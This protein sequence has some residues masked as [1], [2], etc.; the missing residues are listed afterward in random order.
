MLQA[1]VGVAKFWYVAT[2]DPTKLAINANH[3]KYSGKF[4]AMVEYVTNQVLHQQVN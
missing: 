2:H 4:Y 1:G 3:E